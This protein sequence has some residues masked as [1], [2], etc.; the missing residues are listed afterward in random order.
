MVAAVAALVAGVVNAASVTGG[1]VALEAKKRARDACFTV[2][3]WDT[4]LL[5]ARRQVCLSADSFSTPLSSFLEVASAAWPESV[6]APSRCV[7]TT[8][9]RLASA[10]VSNSAG[11]DA[12]ALSAA[13]GAVL[14]RRSRVV[15][16]NVVR[17]FTLEHTV[18]IEPYSTT[19]HTEQ[20][21]LSGRCRTRR[22][23]T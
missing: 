14:R 11:G 2:G 21:I 18:R 20:G 15:C 13:I 1:V 8:A 7:C 23:T 16:V 3:V 10:A 17:T 12:I 6:L 19:S 9:H 22:T 4:S 5:R